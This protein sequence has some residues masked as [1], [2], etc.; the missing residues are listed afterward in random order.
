MVVILQAVG[1]FDTTCSGD[2]QQNQPV[3]GMSVRTIFFAVACLPVAQQEGCI[4][5]S[6][7]CMRSGLSSPLAL[8]S[9]VYA[10]L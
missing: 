8:H 9:V 10:V 4:G 6:C 5:S 1:F 3:R 2:E 7:F